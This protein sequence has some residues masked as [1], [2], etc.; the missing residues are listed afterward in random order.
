ML[1]FTRQHLL[2]QHRRDSP[3]APFSFLKNGKKK[4][5]NL[6]CTGAKPGN[7]FSDPD[8][9]AAATNMD[10]WEDETLNVAPWGVHIATALKAEHCFSENVD[11]IIKDGAVMII[12]QASGRVQEKT[13]WQNML[14]MV[15]ARTF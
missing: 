12:D 10:L 4:S 2:H 14:H 3:T 15:S 11:Y 6:S 13:R 1:R 8:T 7:K 5:R 9:G